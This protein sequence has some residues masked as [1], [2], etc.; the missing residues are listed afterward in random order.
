[1]TWTRVAWIF[2]PPERIE[3]A[4]EL[5]FHVEER[6]REL[7][8]RGMDPER[9]RELAER[10]FGP[11]RP[12]EEALVDSTRRRRQREDRA[13]KL[14]NLRKDLRYTI[15][16]LRRHPGFAAAAV[17]TLALGVGAALAVFTV[18]NGVLVRPLP[19][20][21]PERITMIWTW[22]PEGYALP[23]SS[24]SFNLLSDQQTRFDAVAAFRA[25]PYGFSTP[26]SVESER[27][28]GARR[29]SPPRCSTCSA[30]DRSPAERSPRTKRCRAGRTSPSSVMICGSDASRATAPSLGSRSR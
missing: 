20:K 25:W 16:S 7:I 29:V 13:E 9:A 1:M 23:L 4:D 10:R 6:A 21:D 15:R 18:V 11:V 17:G 5:R 24:G 3:V 22:M 8:E 2:R 19:Y 28:N 12:I 30:S 26:G 14:M 27:V